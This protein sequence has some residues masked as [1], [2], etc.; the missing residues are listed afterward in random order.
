MA[1]SGIGDT[2]LT[3]ILGALKI[4]QRN[5]VVLAEIVTDAAENTRAIAEQAAASPG[6]RVTYAL[7]SRL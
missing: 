4:A 3:L 6:E 2:H 5:Q 7:I 1:I